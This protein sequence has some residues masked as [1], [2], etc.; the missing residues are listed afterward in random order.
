MTTVGYGE[1]TISTD[2]GKIVAII[3]AFWGSFVISLFVLVAGSV[4]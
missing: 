3:T 1:I 4:F 2:L